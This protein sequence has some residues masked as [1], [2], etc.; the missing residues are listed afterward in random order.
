MTR[1]TRP[2]ATGLR[3]S[4]T[5]AT[6][7]RIADDRD[8]AADLREHLADEREHAAENRDRAADQ[9]EHAA[10]DRDQDAELRELLADSRVEFAEHDVAELRTALETR[11]VIEQAKGMVM[12]T[13]KIDA[14]AAFDVL[15]RQS[16]ETHVKLVEVAREIVAAGIRTAD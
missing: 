14:D 5:E 12:L 2:T 8:R 6:P 3:Q 9:R 11:G 13:L 1:N 7:D 10:D 4:A 15:V 16:Q